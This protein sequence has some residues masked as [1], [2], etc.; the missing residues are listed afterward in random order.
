M[1]GPRN[2]RADTYWL[3]FS[4]D[5]NRCKVELRLGGGTSASQRLLPLEA[6]RRI[7]A[8]WQQ[9]DLAPRS[10]L[11]RL[12]ENCGTRLGRQGVPF[13]PPQT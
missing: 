1:P 10:A 4:T 11:I 5:R 12:L 13:T 2:H 6:G 3:L 9:A 8:D 7:H